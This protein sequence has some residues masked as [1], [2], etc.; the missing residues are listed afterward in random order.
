MDFGEALKLIQLLAWC[1]AVPQRNPPP[2]GLSL[3][4]VQALLAACPAELCTPSLLWCGT[5]CRVLTTPGC[6]MLGL[7]QRAGGKDIL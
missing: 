4:P 5:E 2:E 1:V 3:R 6:K 7:N